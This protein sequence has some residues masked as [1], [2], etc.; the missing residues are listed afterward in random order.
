MDF[1]FQNFH[2][3]RKTKEKSSIT[4]PREYEMQIDSRHDGLRVL[5]ESKQ[6]VKQKKK[7][8]KWEGAERINERK[9]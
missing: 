8:M 9:M 5:Q 7:E 3:R 2:S 1:Q 6:V 4:T